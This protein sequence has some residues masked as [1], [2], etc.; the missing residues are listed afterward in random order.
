MAEEMFG[1]ELLELLRKYDT[2]TICNSLELLLGGRRI[3]G[4]TTQPFVCADLKLPLLVG[5][6]RM[7]TLRSS[8]SSPL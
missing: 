3:T 2:P 8:Q 5:F 7:P 4:F 6:G 1:P